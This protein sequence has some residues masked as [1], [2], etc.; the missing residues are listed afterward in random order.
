MVA[1]SAVILIASAGLAID[2]ALGYFVKAKLNAAVNSASLAAARGVTPA[3]TQTKHRRPTR[4]NRPRNFLTSTI[5]T[6]F[7]SPRPYSTPSVWSLTG[8]LTIDVSASASLPVSLMGILGFKTLNVAAGAQTIR[9][10]LDMAL[11]IDK[12]GSLS[13]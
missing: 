2:S 12:S 9:K 7:C 8:Q 6:N 4:G 10:D 3:I 13:G 5:P 1:L 11:V